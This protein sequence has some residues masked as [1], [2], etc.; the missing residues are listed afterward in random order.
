MSQ[1]CSHTPWFR[2]SA[3]K[4]FSVATNEALVAVEG[5]SHLLICHDDVAPS[6]DAVRFLVGEAL[7]SPTPAS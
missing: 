6:P 5:A 2:E 4:G 7:P 1:P 3:S